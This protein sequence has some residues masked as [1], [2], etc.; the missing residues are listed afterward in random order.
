LVKKMQN[1][2][3]GG[4]GFFWWLVAAELGFMGLAS[5]VAA[6]LAKTQTPVAQTRGGTSPAWVLTSGPLP[7]PITVERYF[8]LW[9]FDLIWVLVCVFLAFFY[10][11]GVWRLHRRGDRWPW[12]RTVLWL[13]GLALLFIVT[14][15]GI[16]VY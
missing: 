1:A 6:A 15:G 2:K 4:N 5:G 13:A 14:N 16:N 7:P 12:Y 8:T 3:N 9:N 10:L 11:A